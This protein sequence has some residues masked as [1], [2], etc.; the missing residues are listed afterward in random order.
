MTFKSVDIAKIDNHIYTAQAVGLPCCRT[1]IRLCAVGSVAAMCDC[2]YLAV[3]VQHSVCILVHLKRDE[4]RKT[5]PDV[6]SPASQTCV[7][8]IIFIASSASTRLCANLAHSS[9]DIYFDV[10]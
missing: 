5:V 3:V 2:T 4:L 10:A 1:S 8:V 6:C 7:N 9:E